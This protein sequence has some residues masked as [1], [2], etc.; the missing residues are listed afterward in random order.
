MLIDKA[1][2]KQVEDISAQIIDFLRGGNWDRNPICE[3]SGILEE[4]EDGELPERWTKIINREVTW[5]ID[6]ATRLVLG[7]ID[8]LLF[9]R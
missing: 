9:S 5:G 8:E 1:V 6:N 4:V 7:D 3:I 2:D